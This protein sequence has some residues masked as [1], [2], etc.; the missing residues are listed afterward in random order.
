MLLALLG[1]G[2]CAYPIAAPWIAATIQADVIVQYDQKVT[3]LDPDQRA[4]LLAEAEYYNAHLPNGPLRDPYVLNDSGEAVS[5]DQ[6][7]ADYE[8]QLSVDDGA[9]MARLR[10]PAID[11]DLPVFHGTDE[12]V[13]A[14]GVGH[15][16]GSGLPVGGSGVHS[17]LTAHSGYVNARLF[18]DLDQVKIGDE[19]TITV[20]GDV[21]TYR[22]D[23]IDTVL[24]DE[25]ELLR[26]VPGAD[27]VTLVTCTPRYVNSHRL[28]VRGIRVPTI[29]EP[30]A[31]DAS[32]I[33]SPGDPGFPWWMLII[34]A[35]VGAGLFLLRRPRPTSTD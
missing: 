32:H 25:S 21:L 9:P 17:V 6:G 35:P 19:F 13:L 12:D 34:V 33:V 28:L 5:L 18:D 30:D 31:A 20:L 24:P 7:R 1:G 15:F 14:R 29:S 22:V 10:I 2:F 3:N 8:R 26:Q 4:R 16:Y 23:Q 27:Y 11:V